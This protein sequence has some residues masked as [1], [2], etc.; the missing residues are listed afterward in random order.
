MAS[1]LGSSTVYYPPVGFHFSVK[2]IGL[3]GGEADM[4]FSEVS[5]L[6][7]EIVTEDV[8][9]GGENR[10]IQRYPVRSKYPDLVL[11]RGL[12]VN[13]GIRDWIDQALADMVITPVNVHVALLNPDHQILMGWD[14]VNAWPVKWS[15]SDLNASNNAIVIES[16]S[17]AYQYF[18][19][20]LG[21]GGV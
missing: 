21:S 15:L 6:S 8:P 9:E 1:T 16:L 19:A 18:R 17:L 11:K 20:N 10:F 5:G 14:F 3:P 12:L 4:R 7:A 13:S 2:F